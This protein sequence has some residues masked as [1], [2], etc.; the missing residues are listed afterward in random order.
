[1]MK[2]MPTFSCSD[3]ELRTHLVAQLRIERRERLIQQQHARPL[4]QRARQRHALTLAAGELIRHAIA[5][6][7]QLHQLQRFIDAAS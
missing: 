6:A 3:G 1:M 4:H 5:E 2:V 7:A